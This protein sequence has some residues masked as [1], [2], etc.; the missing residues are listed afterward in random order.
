M[1]GNLASSLSLTGSIGTAGSSTVMAIGANP[2]GSSAS[3]NYYN[4]RVYSVRMYNRA[5][6]DAE[7]QEN[8]KVDNSNYK[9]N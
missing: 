2:A 5:L 6:T 8:Y 1:N 3:S 9:I 7:I 4:G